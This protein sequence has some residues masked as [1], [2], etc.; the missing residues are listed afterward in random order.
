MLKKLFCQCVGLAS[1]ILVMNYG[2]LLGGG[3]DVRMHV[4]FPLG[5]IIM[6][7]IADIFILG[8]AMF[9]AVALLQRTRYYNWVRLVLAIVIPP[10]LIDRTQALYP[11][12]MKDGL[13]PII[14]GIWAALLL[15]LLLKFPR[16]YKRLL[17]TGDAVGVFFA[18]FAFFSIMQL[19]WVTHWKPGPQQHLAAWATSPQPPR[20]HPLVVWIIFDEL[21]YD[22]V[23]EHR[24]HDLNLP[25][26]DA[27]RN[28]STVFTNVQ[29]IGYKTVKI[30]P[31]LLSGQLIDDF[32]YQF[33]NSFLVHFTGQHGWHPLTGSQTVFH[34]AQQNG[35][36]TAV[37]GWYNPYCGIYGDAIDHCY[38]MNLDKIDGLMAQRDN[39]WRNTYS[40]LQQMV[41]EIKAPARADHDACGYDVRQRHQTDSDLQQHSL[42]LLKGD[43]AD[44]VFLHMSVPHSPN[45][46]SRINDQ[47]TNICDSSYLDNLALADRELGRIMQTLQASP[48]WKDTTLIVQGDHSWRIDLWNWL[49]AWTSED[50]AASRG[51]FDPRPAVIVHQAGQIKPQINATTWSLIGIHDVVEQV[52]KRQPVHF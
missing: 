27:L 8:F 36:R 10:Y 30:I 38:W 9:V 22:Q 33:D 20:Q 32:R 11:F 35:W 28:Q 3:A 26:F 13:V 24:A 16:W 15:L 18:V 29:P 39:F 37:V 17:Q 25:H 2:D 51:V 45:I 41:R 52:I 31:S 48:R 49:P 4:P 46:W 7:Q 23:F 5:G 14:A 50:D 34:D 1:L 6:A 47:Y 40:P 42:Q 43:Q 12:V 44:F 19:L 21:S